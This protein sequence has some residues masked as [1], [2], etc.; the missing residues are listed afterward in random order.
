MAEE[1]KLENLKEKYEILQKKYGL[2]S[3]KELNEDFHIDRVAESETEIPIREIRKHI[4]D[5]MA[6]Y[7]RFSETL[8]NPTNA[9]MFIFSII[10]TLSSEDKQ[11][12]S[13]IYKRLSKNELKLIETDLEFSEEKEVEFIKNSYNIWQY[14]KKDILII[15]KSVEDKWD[16]KLEGNKREYFG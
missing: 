9:P 3:F 5:K 8:L 4:A 10:K 11:K 13:E 15:L 1:H 14:M 16:D 12:L 2:P 6:G 7:L